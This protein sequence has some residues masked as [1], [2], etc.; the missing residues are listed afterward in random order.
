M[1]N[2][3]KA[4]FFLRARGSDLQHLETFALMLAT[5]KTSYRETRLRAQG[6]KEGVSLDAKELTTAVDLSVLTYLNKYS[7][8]PGNIKDVL[9]VLSSDSDKHTLAMSWYNA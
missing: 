1:S 9:S 2:I 7:R 5:A 6:N 4:R 3:A 8:L